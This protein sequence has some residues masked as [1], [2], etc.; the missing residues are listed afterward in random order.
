[1][2]PFLSFL[3]RLS[4]GGVAGMF[5]VI[6]GLLVSDHTSSFPIG[7]VV[8]GKLDNTLLFSSPQITSS[9]KEHICLS[10]SNRRPSPQLILLPM[11]PSS[12]QKYSEQSV[13]AVG[14]ASNK[15]SVYVYGGCSVHLTVTALTFTFPACVSFHASAT[16][17]CRSF[18]CLN[19][20]FHFIF[21]I[22]CRLTICFNL[23]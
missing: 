11:I 1:M 2:A 18:I 5:S 12:H 13:L 10:E 4:Q 14:L 19:V 7:K 22:V 21:C 6:V 9:A 15:R 16:C 23:R 3:V 8:G 17:F 20:S